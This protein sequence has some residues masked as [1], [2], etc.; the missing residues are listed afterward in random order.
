IAGTRL[1]ALIGRGADVGGAAA[2]AIGADI[3]LRAGVAVIACRAV[4]QVAKGARAVAIAGT[5]LLA[6]IGRCAG[7]SGAAADAVGADIGLRAGVAVIAGRAVHFV[8]KR[9]CAVAIAGA[10]LLALIGRCARVGGAAADAGGA[11]I[12]LGAGIAVIA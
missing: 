4:R 6:L 2:D 7:V 11:D 10:R 5:R 8:A 1:L 9:A 12:G 3:V